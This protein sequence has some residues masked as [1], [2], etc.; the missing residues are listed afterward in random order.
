MFL[1]DFY[2][3]IFADLLKFSGCLVVNYFQTRKDAYFHAKC[4]DLE[5]CYGVFSKFDP[6]HPYERGL[7]LQ[8]VKRVTDPGLG[9]HEMA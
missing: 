4:L 9:L 5:G 1:A 2:K 8:K 6:L 7:G 3:S